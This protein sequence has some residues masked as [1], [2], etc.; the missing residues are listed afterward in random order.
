MRKRSFH[1]Q[2]LNS[3]NEN[4]N[5][6]ISNNIAFIEQKIKESH[7]YQRAA[8]AHA[9]RNITQNPKYFT[10]CKRFSTA[11]TQIGPLQTVEAQ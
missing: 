9:V 10:Y 11:K 7:E 6:S 4:R 2:L 3:L 5:N 8:E 1:K